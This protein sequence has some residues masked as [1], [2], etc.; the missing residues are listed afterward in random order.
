[1]FT[2][3]KYIQEN[4]SNLRNELTYNKF[5]DCCNFYSEYKLLID[6]INLKIEDVKS[7]LNKLDKQVNN[8][9]NVDYDSNK[10]RVIK[11]TYLKD[12][13]YQIQK[14]ISNL[15]NNFNSLSSEFQNNTSNLNK[16]FNFID[17]CVYQDDLENCNYNN[18]NFNS[19]NSNIKKQQIAFGKNSS[20][21]YDCKNYLINK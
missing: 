5:K 15:L 7:K 18:D 1:M 4:I 13:I 2:K 9:I 21:I 3:D 17:A 10:E 6:K 14:L 12:M 19:I 16:I 20:C 8:S 11:T